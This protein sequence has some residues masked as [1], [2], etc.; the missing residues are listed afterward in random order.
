MT[1]IRRVVTGHDAEG[2][3]VVISDGPTQNIKQNP[4]RPWHRSTEIWK[5]NGSPVVL[6]ATTEDPCP[7]ASPIHPGHQGLVVRFAEIAPE[8]ADV[9]GMSAE[10]AREIFRS[11]GAEGASTFGRGGS[12]HP[13]M[14][15]TE[16][17]D[18][19]V[20]IDGELTMILDK[21]DVVLRAGDVVVQRGTNHAWANRSD[22]VC[23]VMFVL[24]DAKYDDALKAT[25]EA[26]DRAAT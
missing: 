13:L 14:H 6:G 4:A 12:R 2:N 16:T 9:R 24:T 23:R 7:V 8:S 1:F 17:I 11:A 25:L 21:E 26:H 20:V 15:R 18:Y 22:K 3:A 19:A 10:K 5:T